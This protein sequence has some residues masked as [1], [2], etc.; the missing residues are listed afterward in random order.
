[1]AESGTKRTSKAKAAPLKHAAPD[2]LSAAGADLW[3]KIV[4]ELDDGWQFDERELYLL[5]QA[6]HTADLIADLEAAVAADGVTAK[7]SRG[8]PVVNPA[9]TEI[10][11]LD[12]AQIR[13]LGALEL[14]DPTPPPSSPGQRRA[15]AAATR[16]A[17]SR[18][19]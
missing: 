14:E 2:G 18:R 3:A 1:M 13:L 12:L 6:A 4:G 5:Q 17:G 9:I 11:Q 16:R 8:Q 19:G 15:L 7:G 10:R